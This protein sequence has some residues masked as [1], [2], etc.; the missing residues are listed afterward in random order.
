MNAPDYIFDMKQLTTVSV[1][2]LST[3]V[4]ISGKN[5]CCS[6]M[7][8][9]I[10]L[11]TRGAISFCF[12]EEGRH[13]YSWKLKKK[14]KTTQQLTEKQSRWMNITTGKRGE[15][16]LLDGFCRSTFPQSRTWK[17]VQ[18][19]GFWWAV[20]ELFSTLSASPINHMSLMSWC[21]GWMVTAIRESLD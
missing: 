12:I 3:L 16:S 2:Y 17:H 13:H 10:D 7:C 21:I 14:K 9:F 20:Q 18:G 15:L 6:L 1:D 5:H 4:M 8:C 11:S 19:V